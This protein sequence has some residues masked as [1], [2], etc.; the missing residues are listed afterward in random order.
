MF[1]IKFPHN[2]DSP[3][4]ATSIIVFWERW[5]RTLT[6]FLREYVY[7]TLGGNRLGHVRQIF[8]IMI[9]MLL[10]GLWHVRGGPLSFGARCTVPFWS[11]TTSGA[12][13]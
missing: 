9:T 2:F 12:C 10:S 8:N 7:Y 11:S 1:G 4:R 13:G 3:Y 5:H 6:R